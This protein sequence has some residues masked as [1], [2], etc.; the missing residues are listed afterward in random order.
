MLENFKKHWLIRSGEALKKLQKKL[1]D[2]CK[3]S[4]NQVY[5]HFAEV[6]KLVSIGSGAER[7]VEDFM[8]IRYACCLI[9]SH[10]VVDKLCCSTSRNATMAGA[11]TCL[12]P[13]TAPRLKVCS[14]SFSQA[15][16]Q[17]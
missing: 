12:P 16:L 1:W 17:Y 11:P 4:G 2:A 15:L 8:L 6:R 3:A 5:D 10:N 7:E 13:C 14:R 9:V